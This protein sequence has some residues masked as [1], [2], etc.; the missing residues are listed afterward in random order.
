MPRVPY[1][2]IL[3]NLSLSQLDITPTL[4]TQPTSN[5]TGVT[6]TG[7]CGVITTYS[8]GST[9]ATAGSSSFVVT[10]SAV[11]ASSVVLAS[12]VNYAGTT[13]LPA[14]RV[15]GITQGSFSVVVQNASHVDP[16]NGVL[17][18]GFFAI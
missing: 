13:G 12:V 2:T 3:N 5:T 1:R 9:L 11:K 14:V 17:R 10:N 6:C 16:L 7:D 15:S 4:S 18:V 8:A